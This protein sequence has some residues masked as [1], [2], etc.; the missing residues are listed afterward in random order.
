MSHKWQYWY[1]HKYHHL[2]MTLH[3]TLKMTTAQVVETSVINNSLPKGY[4][5]P[6][7][8]DKPITD[9]CVLTFSHKVK[10]NHLRL[11]LRAL[12][13]SIATDAWACL[14][15]CMTFA[16]RTSLLVNASS[17]F[18]SVHTQTRY[19]CLKHQFKAALIIRHAVY[20]QSHNHLSKTSFLYDL[21]VERVYSLSCSFDILWRDEWP[22]REQMPCIVVYIYLSYINL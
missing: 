21:A 20:I 12:T 9:T 22:L 15:L 19:N 1:M 6:D 14:M 13:C 2:T 3:L 5:H 11:L 16:S 7:D 10:N 4:P 8:H 17:M 18:I